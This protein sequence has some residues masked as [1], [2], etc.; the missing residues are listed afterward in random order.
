MLIDAAR[1]GCEVR[2]LMDASYYNIEPDDPID[3]D[4]TAEYINE[5][6]LAEGLDM[7][8]KIVTQSEHDFT[9]IHNKGMI[10]D[11]KVLI[12]SINWNLNS[13]TKNRET[14]IIIENVQA[15]DFFTEIF[16]YDWKDDTTP[17]YA[18]FSYDPSY[19]VNTTVQF[20]S[21]TSFDNVEIVNYTW[22]LDGQPISW[23]ANLTHNFTQ[24]GFCDLNLTVEDAWCNKGWVEHTLNITALEITDSIADE[25][26]PDNNNETT[27][28]ST[29]YDSK[30]MAVLLLVPVFIFVA[31]VY[32]MYI[33]NR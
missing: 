10:V 13:V 17:P 24:V 1:R 2:V 26:V 28:P 20:S 22:S 6:A 32:I 23:D 5:I 7:E 8:A 30:V 14:G 4:D 25:S 12:S 27:D 31:V 15:A 11:N 9:K 3:N 21:N 16:D 33:R 19:A 18:H 29:D